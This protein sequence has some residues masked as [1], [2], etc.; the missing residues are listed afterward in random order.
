MHMLLFMGVWGYSR[1]GCCEEVVRSV[2][3][4]G[5]VCVFVFVI[6]TVYTHASIYPSINQTQ[7]K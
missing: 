4:G 7:H 6:S 5:Y 3:G 2:F 1:S